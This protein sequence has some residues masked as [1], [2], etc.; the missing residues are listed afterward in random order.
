MRILLAGG[1]SGGHVTPLKAVSES[2]RQLS[3]DPVEITVLTNN[4]FYSETKAIFADDTNITLKKIFSGK[5]RRY[6]SKSFLWHIAHLPTLL[7]NIRDV[8]LLGLGLVQS[9][10][11]FLAHKPDL[12]FCKGGFVCVPIGLTARLFKVP[13]IIH[14]SDTRPGLTNRILSRWAAKICTGM[15][16]EFYPYP[17][18]R[19]VY[20]GIPV[21][22]QYHPISKSRQ[23]TYKESLQLNPDLPMI[24][25]TGGGNGAV[26]LNKQV[27]AAAPVLLSAGFSIVQLAGKGKTGDVVQARSVLPDYLQKNWQIEEF[28]AMVPRLLAADIVVAR[29]SASTLQECA[30]TEKTVI[31]IASPHLDDQKMNAEFFASKNTILSLDETTLSADGYEL[32]EAAM[33]LAKNSHTAAEY[34][35]KLHKEFAKPAAA[36]ELAAIILG[37]NHA[38]SSN[39]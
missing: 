28:A 36:D 10:W 17:K 14:D 12:V 37:Q 29:T 5:Y 31:G 25:F 3:K 7:K 32:A 23:R 21:N 6:K 34:A 15:P 16:A 19:M 9:V 38:H 35:D 30:N 2:L 24:L 27:A 22:T 18:D 4:G 13:L 20:T 39:K 1:G 11:Y 26:S 33:Q 8:F